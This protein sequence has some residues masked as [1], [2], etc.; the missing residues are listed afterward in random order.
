MEH[1]AR[2]RWELMWVSDGPPGPCD[3]GS[4]HLRRTQ[5]Q[6]KGKK[7]AGSQ[8]PACARGHSLGLTH[9]PLCV[10]VTQT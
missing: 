6:Q 1:L 8:S 5:F 3:P 10:T 2:D 9:G 7:D 4:D